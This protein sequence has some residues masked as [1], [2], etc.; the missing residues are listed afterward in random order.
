LAELDDLKAFGLNGATVTI[1]TF[2]RSQR[3]GQPPVFTGRWID[4]DEPLI[5]A[6]RQAVGEAREMIA[7]T[8]PYGLLAQPNEGSALIIGADETHAPQIIDE[9]A[10]PTPKRK[11]KKLKE[12]NNSP[13]YVVKLVSNGQ[14]LYAVN[15]TDT[16]W[17]SRK[18]AS[19]FNVAFGDEGLTLDTRQRFNISRYFDFLIHKGTIFVR[20]KG[21]FESLLSYK[22]SQI[23]DF[24]A[25]QAE[26]AFMGIISD[27]APLAA[28]VGA[29]RIHLRR[30]C[31]IREKGHY[32]DADFMARLRQHHVAMDLTIDFDDQGR[33]VPTEATCR[34]IIQALLDHRLDSRLSG[35]LYDVENT[36]PVG[37]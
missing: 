14:C 2:K 8:H 7:E 15:K 3:T 35:R 10:D 36:E 37:N 23:E 24:T 31:A 29:N 6:L 27:L 25:L 5:A 32:R 34:D 28:F 16:S 21:H 33:I 26:P 13:F 19:A 17:S 22:E 18:S 30:A 20:H 4:A 11:I 1:W 9:T 12:I